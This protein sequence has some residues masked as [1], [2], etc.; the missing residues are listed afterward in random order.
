MNSREDSILYN[1]LEDI[2]PWGYF[3]RYTHNEKCTV[4]IL[5]VNPNQVL[6]KQ[7]HEKRDELWVFI[8]A[9]LRV[10]LGDKVIEPKAGDEIVIPRK[11]PHRLSSLG[12]TGRVLEISFG[13]FSE[14]D[15]ARLDDIYGRE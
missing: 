14:N 10:E 1:I 3:K 9:G 7:V 13:H 6:S 5:T 15:I 11:V 2:R 8:D 4:K 12:G